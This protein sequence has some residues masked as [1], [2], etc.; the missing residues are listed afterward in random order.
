MFAGSAGRTCEAHALVGHFQHD[1]GDGLKTFARDALPTLGAGHLEPSSVGHPARQHRLSF[2]AWGQYVP[3]SHTEARQGT[4]E[5]P[6]L[7]R[8]EPE[9]D[10]GELPQARCALSLTRP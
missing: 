8:R 6:T 9:I 4:T 3:L 2:V 7:L 10:Q 1:S 5:A